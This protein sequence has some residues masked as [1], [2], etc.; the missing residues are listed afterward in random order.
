M[1]NKVLALGFLLTLVLG[2]I[3]IQS[4]A[5]QAALAPAPVQVV[6]SSTVTL[7]NGDKVNFVPD[8]LPK[9][10]DPV[11]HTN[12]HY[13]WGWVT[14]TVYLTK[15]ETRSLR[16][17]SYAVIVAAG[18]CAAFGWETAGAACV[19]SGT[20]TAQWNYVA[21]NAVSAGACVKIKIPIMWAYQYPSGGDCH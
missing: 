15:A 12:I 11:N 18:I 2:S 1:R 16:T 17:Y 20:M 4:T 10:T 13:T 7:S 8:Q 5:T 9:T 6:P 3:G 19:V 14:G 21:S